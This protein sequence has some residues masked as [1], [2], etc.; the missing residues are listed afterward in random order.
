[1]S[2]PTVSTPLDA[3]LD[4]FPI[5]LFVIGPDD[6]YVGYRAGRSTNLFVPP[7]Q[8]LGRT[9]ADVL[10]PEVAPGVV[11]A[12]R[13][14]RRSG[15]QQLHDYSLP[16]EGR[17]RHYEAR[18]VPLSEGHAAALVTDVTERRKAEQGHRETADRLR[19]IFENDPE[20]LKIVDSDGSLLDMNPAGLRMLEADSLAT[21]QSRPLLEFVAP[22]HREAFLALARRVFAGGSGSLRFELVG[23]AGTRRWLETHAVPLRF[24]HSP[25]IR[26][27]GITR[28]VTEE[29]RL[30]QQYLQ[31]QKLES[32]GRLAGGIAHDFNNVLTAI[33][34]YTELLERQLQDSPRCLE[35]VREIRRAGQRAGNLTRQLLAFARKQMFSP[36]SV[37]LNRLVSDVERM[38]ER[39]L[40]EDI[41]LETRLAESLSPVRVDPS[42]IE[43]VL[44]NLAVNARDAMPA[45]GTLTVATFEVPADSTF[46]DADPAVPP[47]DYVGL[48]VSDTGSGISAEDLPHIFEPFYT[49]KP[50]GVGTGLGLAMVYGV[51]RQ[52]QGYVSVQSRP[53][54][55]SSFTLLFPRVDDAPAAEPPAEIDR[56]PGRGSGTIVL[57][58]D[59]AM[60][61]ALAERTLGEAGYR[62]LAC[63]DPER[64]PGLFADVEG[65]VDLLVT[66][67]VM[68]GMSGTLLASR[69]AE[70]YPDVP[71]LCISGYA[72]EA[73]LRA[74]DELGLDFLAKPFTPSALLE[75]VRAA[76]ER[77]RGR[78]APPPGGSPAT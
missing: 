11:G 35:E 57:V 6:R 42:Q 25:A 60:V 68:P 4:A 41:R 43:Q 13:E 24:E 77:A 30:E 67:L 5:L 16:I 58:E 20:C 78:G 75:R 21:A 22:D 7:E 2:S 62:V 56:A 39:L 14:C 32:V 65:R 10:P 40:G 59:D 72:E 70:R 29:R 69:I 19:A 34:G 36:R 71:V 28:D 49:T 64:A 17:L 73:S 76:M 44:L 9:I 8:F 23:L 61:R 53:G 18:F 33:L 37:D 50:T 47:G 26:M 38:L 48:R 55:G 52:S 3:I 54:K 12:V 66:D 74:T 27:L 45:G 31:A 51:V 1:M 46:P 63:G 15:T